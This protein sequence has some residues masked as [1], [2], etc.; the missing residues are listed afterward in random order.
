[1][2]DELFFTMTD[3]STDLTLKT[4]EMDSGST[5]LLQFEFIV[6]ISLVFPS[7]DVHFYFLF[8]VITT[9]LYIVIQTFY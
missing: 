9:R 7:T 2:S 4:H 5:F 1:M 6:K 3:R 8:I